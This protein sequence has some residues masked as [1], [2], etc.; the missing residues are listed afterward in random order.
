M[1][2][3]LARIRF[4]PRHSLIFFNTTRNVGSFSRPAPPLLPAK[5][6]QEME[7]LIRAASSTAAAVSPAAGS[8]PVLHPDARVQPPPEFEGDTNPITGEVGGPKREPL[9][10]G[11][12]SF[13]GRAT[14]F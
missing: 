1:T 11:D 8:N 13:G 5:D 7:D 10:H 3:M 2:T 14:D 12:W 9:R 4:P 6:Q